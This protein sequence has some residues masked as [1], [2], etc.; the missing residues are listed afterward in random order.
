MIIYF[1]GNLRERQERYLVRILKYRLFTYFWAKP[2]A[3]FHVD[4]KRVINSM[5]G[6][7]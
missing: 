6:C 1:G 5:R 3:D 7:R 4:Y 2:G